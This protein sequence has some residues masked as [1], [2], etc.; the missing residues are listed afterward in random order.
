MVKSA[1]KE[2]LYAAEGARLAAELER[3]SIGPSEFSRMLAREYGLTAGPQNVQNW[4]RG[5]GFNPKNQRM[6]AALLGLEP[7]AFDDGSK[8]GT[9]QPPVAR[10]ASLARLLSERKL[11]RY[12]V[13]VLRALDALNADDPGDRYWEALADMH[14]GIAAST[15]A[16]RF[17]PAQRRSHRA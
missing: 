12:T 16:S 1:D 9:E 13:D 2:T 17:K 14:E 5:R 4:K 7:D 8:R 11:R 15:E 3:R 10:N 6:C